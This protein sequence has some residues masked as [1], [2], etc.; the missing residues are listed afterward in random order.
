MVWDWFR[1]VCSLQVLNCATAEITVAHYQG[2]IF[3]YKRVVSP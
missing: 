2:A 1:E 3:P